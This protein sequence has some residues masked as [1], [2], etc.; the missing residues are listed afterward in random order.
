MG[1]TC[2][3]INVRNFVIMHRDTENAMGQ[4]N[5]SAQF[6]KMSVDFYYEE[7][8][9]GAK[10]GGVYVVTL[11]VEG[12]AIADAKGSKKGIKNMVAKKALDYL[13]TIC[14][15][16]VLNNKDGKIDRRNIMSR[17]D[18]KRT[19]E[20]VSQENKEKSFGDFGSK[21]LEQMGW[22]EGESLGVSGDSAS[23]IREP[24]T[25]N[26]IALKY[27]NKDQFV[28]FAVERECQQ[29][30]SWIPSNQR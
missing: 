27:K 28:F 3:G 4:L 18:I 15:T 23:N 8:D 13:R 30:G 5:S 11:F 24:V 6:G 19:S 25:V 22:K 26:L 10:G 9:K 17:N 21:M 1:P 29:G 2:S 14:Y 16:V 12:Q 20:F 7:I